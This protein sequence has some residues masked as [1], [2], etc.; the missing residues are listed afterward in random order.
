MRAAKFK[1]AFAAF[2]I[3]ILVAA[4]QAQQAPAPNAPAFVASAGGPRRGARRASDRYRSARRPFDGPERRVDDRACLADRPR[5]RRCD[6]HGA[7]QLL[8]HGKTAGHDL[9][10]RLGPWRRDQDL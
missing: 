7:G 2:I 10:V 4:P 5:R 1:A 9:A 8:I 6:G 3:V